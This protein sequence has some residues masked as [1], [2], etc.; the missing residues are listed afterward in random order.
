MNALHFPR[1]RKPFGCVHIHSLSPWERAGV[2]AR[3]TMA[4][5]PALAPTPAL[6]QRGREQY[7][8]GR[9]A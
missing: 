9:M 4:I 5:A 3:A 2:R 7:R 8:A 6:P 1:E